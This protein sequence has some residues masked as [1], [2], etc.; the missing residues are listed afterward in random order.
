MLLPTPQGLSPQGHSALATMILALGLWSTEALP[1]GITSVTSVIILAASAGADEAEQSS[2][3][4]D[5][6]SRTP[7]TPEISLYDLFEWERANPSHTA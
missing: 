5:G 6:T 4:H 1:I 3:S 7:C 2:E